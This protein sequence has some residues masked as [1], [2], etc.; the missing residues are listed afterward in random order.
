[1]GRVSALHWIVDVNRAM[2]NWQ[3]IRDLIPRMLEN[4]SK[5]PALVDDLVDYALR[6]TPPNQ[7]LFYEAIEGLSNDQI[8]QMHKSGIQLFINGFQ[9]FNQGDRARQL[10]VGLT[11]TKLVEEDKKVDVAKRLNHGERLSILD[12]FEQNPWEWR[13]DD[14]LTVA[15]AYFNEVQYEKS[16]AVYERF[17]VFNPN[18]IH[19]FTG[20]GNCYLCQTNFE[21]AILQYRKAWDMGDSNVVH[22]L[23]AAY[24]GSTNNSVERMRDL[25]PCLMKNKL[26][27]LVFILGFA[28]YVT[29]PDKELFMKAVEG[30]TD[31][32]LLKNESVT[33]LAISGFEQ[34]GQ[35]D[36]AAALKA[37]WQKQL[38]K[39]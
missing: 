6:Q 13:D 1:M 33:K 4:K 12:K 25:I 7:K 29:P 34:F 38:L 3:A 30:V 21:E 10:S 15:I 27:N 24:I 37:K 20:L 22:T 31:S 8:I 16:K 18:D 28:L 36:R 5:D 17:A 26:E 2:K 14:L 39:R 19:V 9:I 23:A 35:K 32:E 11:E